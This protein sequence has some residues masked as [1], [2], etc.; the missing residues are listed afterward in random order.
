MMFLYTI[1]DT[2][3][4]LRTR[5]V[6]RMVLPNPPD[7]SK[8][9][10]YTNAGYMLA[11]AMLERLTGETW[12]DLMQQHVFDALGMPDAGFGAPGPDQPLGHRETADGSWSEVAPGPAADNPPAL[13]PA[14]TVHTNHTSWT[15]YL[16]AQLDI[17]QGREGPFTGEVFAVL[18]QPS[19]DHPYAGGWLISDEL[20][21]IPGPILAH[22][23]SN[24]MWLSTVFVL[25][26][27]NAAFI[28]N[29]NAYANESTEGCVRLLTELLDIPSETRSEND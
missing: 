18:H 24:T 2:P 27:Q 14:G 29:T 6:E 1:D 25:P 17:A 8:D 23:G 12:E 26:S 3:A 4:N 22:Q 5:W 11:G 16:A 20:A 10:R 13:G 9:Y 7:P 19:E 15:P 28:C 21:G